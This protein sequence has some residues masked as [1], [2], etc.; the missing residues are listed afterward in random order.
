MDDATCVVGWDD[1]AWCEDSFEG[2]PETFEELAT[3][4]SRMLMRGS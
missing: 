2:K 3:M 1:W 4:V